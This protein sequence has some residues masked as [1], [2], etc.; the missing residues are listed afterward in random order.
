[1]SNHK[2]AVSIHS[3]RCKYIL[4]NDVNIYFQIIKYNNDSN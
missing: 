4:S 3:D 1:M 2:S